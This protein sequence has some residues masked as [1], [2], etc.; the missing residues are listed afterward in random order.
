MK[1]VRMLGSPVV[2]TVV[3]A[4]CASQPGAPAT[5]PTGVPEEAAVTEPPAAPPGAFA[6]VRYGLTTSVT[7]DSSNTPAGY[8][9]GIPFP[10]SASQ[11]SVSGCD[12]DQSE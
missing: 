6:T 8:T 3:L 11:R 4:A 2:F 9:S 5:R 7:V 1:A 12:M 10:S